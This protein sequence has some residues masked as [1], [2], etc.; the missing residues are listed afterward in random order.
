MTTLSSP[1]AL[2]TPQPSSLRA[3]VWRAELAVRRHWERLR[4]AAQLRRLRRLARTAAPRQAGRVRVG[5]LSVAYDDA[6]SLYFEYK[7]IFAQRIYDFRPAGARP[8]ILDCG[9]HIGL[10]VLRFKQ[11]APD[12]RIVA[13]EPDPRVLPLL[14]DNLAANRLA[15]IEVVPAALHTHRGEQAFAA[16][17][18]DGGR[19]HIAGDTATCAAA[20]QTVR[21][22]DYLAEPVEFLKLNIEGAE[23]DVLHEAAPRLRQ[24]RRIVVE[25]HGFPEL[26]ERLGE[27]LDLLTRCGFR[28]V[29]GSF[30]AETNPVAHPPFRIARDSRWFALIAGERLD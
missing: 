10:S 4:N 3:L 24:V 29:V 7:H 9:T 2:A 28:C 22:S 1:A 6:R 17:G 12:A 30:D 18:V 25:H 16:D 8:R 26:G 14:R 23:V 15:D 5:G 20:V 21:L 27:L 11:L 13:F 19:L